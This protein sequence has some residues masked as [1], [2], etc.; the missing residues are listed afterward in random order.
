ME[1]LVICTMLRAHAGYQARTIM[2][3]CF[4]ALFS[5]CAHY[6]VN[7]SLERHDPNSGYR[8]ET[9]PS[10][11]NSGSLLVALSF[12]G[13]GTRAAALAYGTLER[14]ARTEIAWEGRRKRLLDEVDIISSVSGGSYTA[15]YYALYRDRLFEDFEVEFLKRNV[16]GEITRKLLTPTSLVRSWSPRFGRSDL[17]AE[18]LDD[19]L[20][21]DA[22]FADLQRQ[23]RPFVLI[24]ASD[25]SLGTRFE[26]S[27]D[28][29]DLLCSDLSPY[30]LSRA[31]AASSAVPIALTPLTLRNYAGS[32]DYQ[33]PGW[34]QA[35]LTDR[36]SS[37][38]RYYKASELRSYLDAER[39]PYIHLLDGAL[40]DNTGLRALLDRILSREDPLRPAK[41]LDTQA[42][43]KVVLIM[44]SAE[45][46]PDLSIDRIGS[47]PT[48][49]QVVRNVKDT[50]INRY[51]F[52]TIEL[53]KAYF[54]GWAQRPREHAEDVPPTEFYL[55]EVTLEAIEDE[56]Q[57]E[58]FMAIPTSLHLPADQV[59]AL[60]ATA[61]RL[62]DESPGFRRLMDDL[63]RE[64]RG[65]N[66]YS[67]PSL[68][69]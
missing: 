34:V 16:Q 55:V 38:R 56:R 20:F 50:P 6:P 46:R 47:V 26:F 59:D 18:Y 1:K 62:L 64:N 65:L 14:L 66:D 49:M 33:E 44:V 2:S 15:A 19:Q 40:S 3:L 25:L 45:T 35:A 28:Q 61:G 12:S 17:M 10:G 27:Q 23:G 51:S 58:D 5:G 13:G 30:P 48:P 63:G 60:R 52:E 53:F 29:F 32:C 36:A 67:T 9:L 41:A 8:L 7:T 69:F 68:E 4:A 37:A 24:N 22:T 42:L 31:V 11:G 21:H 57:R 54:D 43:R 39:R